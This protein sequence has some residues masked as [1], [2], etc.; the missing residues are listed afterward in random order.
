MK[1]KAISFKKFL[2][3]KND[4]YK[5]INIVSKRARQI[6]DFRYS[7]IEAMQNI[8]D[9]DQLEEINNIEFDQ[10]KSISKAMTEL[11]DD[12]LEYRDVGDSDQTDDEEWT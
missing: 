7:K 12:E 6:N 11:L 1:V 10:Q 4:I 9:S 5:N 2:K 3:N 8:E